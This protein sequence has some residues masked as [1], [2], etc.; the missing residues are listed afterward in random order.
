LKTFGCL[1][2]ASTP[3]INRNKLDPRAR[4]CVFIGF[5]NG[6]KGHILLDLKSREIF[7]STN[8]L[9]YETI[10]PCSSTETTIVEKN[11]HMN[12]DFSF[13]NDSHIN[14]REDHFAL[15]NFAGEIQ[16]NDSTTDDEEDKTT[17]SSNLQQTEPEQIM[18]Q[19]AQA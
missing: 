10:F 18:N 17:N 7:I 13:L 9:F 1:S 14:I 6:I 12:Q 4:K 11:N 16:E 15:D 8:A 5:K 3:D 19:P 2:F